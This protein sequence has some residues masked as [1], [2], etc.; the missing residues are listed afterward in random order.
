MID[1]RSV[2][3]VKIQC[4]GH[5]AEQALMI[6]AL[7]A[8]RSH[9]HLSIVL[10]SDSDIAP[11]LQDIVGHDAHESSSFHVDQSVVLGPK[12]PWLGGHRVLDFVAALGVES[13]MSRDWV[14]PLSDSQHQYARQLLVEAGRR[15]DRPLLGVVVGGGMGDH[16]GDPDQLVLALTQLRDKYDVDV[17]VM[18]LSDSERAA[19]ARVSARLSDH[20]MVAS[21]WSV[22][23]FPAI[24]AQCDGIVGGESALLHVGAFLKRPIVGL[25]PM[26]VVKPIHWGPWATRC[27]I[28]TAEFA[29]GQSCSIRGCP[30]T[31]C[32]DALTT[33]RL[34]TAI[35]VVLAGGGDASPR[36]LAQI[37]HSVLVVV[38]ADTQALGHRLATHVQGSGVP[39]SVVDV[40]DRSLA[41][42]IQALNVTQIHLLART[43]RWVVRVGAW[44]AMRRQGTL[45]R[46]VTNAYL[47]KDYHDTY[48]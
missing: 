45:P 30:L 36:Y 37:S 42:K 25:Y 21:D 41:R 43:R 44:L 27:Q 23:D 14:F 40:S 31:L 39:V 29:C 34:V 13:T 15:P 35:Q 48:L 12:V 28:V 10:E 19:A 18:A 4:R 38:D 11:L 24:L 6:P 33:D 22:R 9:R 1:W 26:R 32:T 20:V 7:A 16:S 17:V 47:D 2:Q 46:I 3:V 5:R 8:L